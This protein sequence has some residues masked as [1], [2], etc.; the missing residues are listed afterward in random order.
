MS[1]IGMILFIL[2]ISL[3]VNFDRLCLSWNWPI[4]S[5]LSNLGYRFSTIFT[6]CLFHSKISSDGSLLF[7]ILVICIIF[8]LDIHFIFH[9]FKYDYIL[10][11]IS[12]ERNWSACC[13]KVSLIFF[14]WWKMWITDGNKL[15]YCYQILICT[16]GKWREWY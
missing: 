10:F 7:L 3:C 9:Y 1:L 8:F 16:L 6:Y 4:L 14:C 5:R 15:N 13:E 11:S 2:Y 12:R